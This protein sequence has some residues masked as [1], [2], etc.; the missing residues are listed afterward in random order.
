MS[1]TGLLRIETCTS[2]ET[3]EN[4]R[5]RFGHDERSET[6]PECDGAVVSEE[7]ERVCEECGLV[8]AETTVDH[9]PEWRA[10]SAAERDERARCGSPI[11]ETLHDK[12][13][14]TE[15]D[16]R[17]EDANGNR[18]D[19]RQRRRARK[20]RLVQRYSK[21]AQ[22]REESLRDGRGEINRMC[23]ALGVAQFVRECAGRLYDQSV[24]TG[25]LPGWS[26]EDVATAVLHITLEQVGQPRDIEEILPVSQASKAKVL[27]S[28]KQIL[29]EFDLWGSVV[30]DEDDLREAIAQHIRRLV[31]DV[32]AIPVIERAATDL[33]A[34]TD[35]AQLGDGRKPMSYAA[36]FVFEAGR[37]LDI[38][39]APTQQEIHDVGG[40]CA[41]TIRTAGKSVIENIGT[42]ALGEI[43]EDID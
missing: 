22:S 34:A 13:L 39:E 23:S 30:P 41:K 20:N 19:G 10:G 36:A 4:T 38:P 15:I 8:V 21:T 29:N 5:E 28:R 35:Y 2:V 17:N 26:R 32:E 40:P 16:W 12:G 25:I 24:H 14:T 6:C 37:L 33:L 1:K 42:E 3:G 9:G 18:L 43:I 31:S 11:T 7:S 27:R